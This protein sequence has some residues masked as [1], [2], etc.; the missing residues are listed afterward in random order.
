MYQVL[1]N[2]LSNA[3]K[4]TPR[5]GRITVRLAPRDDAKVE[6]SIADTGEGISSEFLPFVFDRFR[7]ADGSTTRHHG[8]LGVGLS[9]ARY[10]VE[11][12]GGSIRAESPGPGMGSIFTITL[13]LLVDRGKGKLP[14]FDSD[15]QEESPEQQ[16]SLHQV[17]ILIVDDD[18]DASE[19][20]QKALMRSGAEVRTAS[21]VKEALSLLESWKP[22][23]LL[24]DIGMPDEDGFALIEKLRSLPPEQGGC[25]PAASLTAYT[26]EE[27]QK[28]AIA[29]GFNIHISKPVSVTEL[30]SSVRELWTMRN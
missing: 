25:I 30:L 28:R 15:D 23:M 21:S 1:W 24:S 7:Q 11:L 16:D 14:S 17:R 19:L 26:R 4:F 10:L 20:F 12:H 5:D 27:D 13:P 22:E 2:L 3:I 29:A 6:L 18:F 8:G 9:I